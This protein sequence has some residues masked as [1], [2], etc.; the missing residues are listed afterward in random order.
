[1]IEEL[2][3]DQR[4][5]DTAK[6]IRNGNAKYKRK[7][8]DQRGRALCKRIFVEQKPQKSVFKPI[9]DTPDQK[10]H[11]APSLSDIA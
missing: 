10:R 8:D 3:D 6:Q 7:P 4:K 11:S 1:V 5:I 9:I 2:R